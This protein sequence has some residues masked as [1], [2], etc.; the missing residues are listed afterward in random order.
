MKKYMVNG[1]NAAGWRIAEVGRNGYIA[2]AP[3][4]VVAD[5]ICRLLNESE[6]LTYKDS[7]LPPKICQVCK[8][9]V[10]PFDKKHVLIKNLEGGESAL[11][12]GA[13]EEAEGAG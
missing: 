8:E 11:L 12:C 3:D 9:E 1:A 6:A 2:L 4:K 5:W 10:Q 13:Q 7:K